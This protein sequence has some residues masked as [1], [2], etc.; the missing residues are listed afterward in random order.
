MTASDKNR[1]SNWIENHNGQWNRKENRICTIVSHPHDRP[2]RE[3]YNLKSLWVGRTMKNLEVTFISNIVWKGFSNT[4]DSST[5]FIC[6]RTSVME[7]LFPLS[8]DSTRQKRTL[9]EQTGGR[10]WKRQKNQIKSNQNSFQ[11]VV[12]HLTICIAGRTN[13]LFNAI[14]KIFDL[15]RDCWIA[16]IHRSGAVA[17]HALINRQWRCVTNKKMHTSKGIWRQLW[18]YI[19]LLLITTTSEVLPSSTFSVGQEIRNPL[20]WCSASKI[21]HFRNLTQFHFTFQL[22]YVSVCEWVEY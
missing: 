7:W 9:I 3:Y 10:E 1:L 21:I 17:I 13:A 2:E 16:L 5:R 4:I 15:R 11:S 6:L 19:S 18:Y 22:L 12:T 20:V 8:K 14:N